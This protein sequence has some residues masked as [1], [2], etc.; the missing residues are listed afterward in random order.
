MPKDIVVVGC[1]A[2]GMM[3]ALFA[4][5]AKAGVTIIERNHRPG[6][7]LAIT[8]K[9]RCNITNAC[10][11]KELVSNVPTNGRF[12]YS[13][14]NYLDSG[15]TMEL[16]E[17]IGIRLTTERG[18]RVFPA[19]DSAHEVIQQLHG[20]LIRLGVRMY[21]DTRVQSINKSTNGTFTVECSG[22]IRTIKADS[23]VLATG[24][25]SYPR[26]GS[27]GDGYKFAASLGHMIVPLWPALVPLEVAETWVRDV[28]GLSLK[29]VE[30]IAPSGR[31][32][33]E[34]LFTHFGISGPI[35]LSLS[36]HL[37][38]DLMQGHVVLRLDL[39]PALTQEAV[40]A[41]LRRD[42]A[43]AGR[44]FFGNSMSDLLPAS[45]IPVFVKL[46]QIPHDRQVSQITKEQFERVSF[47]LKNLELTVV[48]QR[49]LAEAIVTAGGVKT[50]EVDPRTMES[51]LVSGLYFAGEILDVDAYTGGYNLQIAWSTGAVAGE[52]AAREN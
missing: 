29:N 42:F 48:G 19:S 20:E 43:Q 50:S 6:V 21:M 22:G 52:S 38:K 12:L 46:A 7:K 9:G 35:V 33:G 15:S 49:P 30:L 27:S 2:A 41:R 39:K 18:R 1:G 16:F 32:F 17:S 5:R 44:K 10:T 11:V 34:M 45:L 28:Q 31:E 23:V 47:M 13:A 51:K 36:S 37:R 24:G 4:A 40:E 8:G 25:A 26:T 3:A 14:F